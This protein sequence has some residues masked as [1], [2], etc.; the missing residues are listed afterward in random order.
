MS[1]FL[2]SADFSLSSKKTMWPTAGFLGTD[3]DG[4]ASDQG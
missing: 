4:E 2:L 3:G 1:F